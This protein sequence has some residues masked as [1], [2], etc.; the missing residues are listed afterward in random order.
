LPGAVTSCMHGGQ[1]C[2]IPSRIMVPRARYDEAVDLVMSGYASWNYGDPTDANNLQG[3]Q[4][5]KKQQERV[6]GYIEKGKAEGARVV[7]G[8]GVPKHLPKGFYVEPT[9]FAD[10][11]N[12]MTIAQE[13]IFGPVLV[14]IPFDDDDDAVRIANESMYGLSGAVASASEER[15][16]GVARRIRT[17]TVGVNGGIWFGP[18]APFG[19]Y[20]QS[21]V[22]RENGV[23][24]FEEYL[25]VKTVALPAKPQS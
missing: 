20:R 10:V 8:G 1:G 13:E 7:T 19:G 11:E 5:S 4:I 23:E 6:L 25:E 16:L 12:T 3:P 14:L 18:D 22:G 15:A 17:G 9:L 2:A 24:G 21:G